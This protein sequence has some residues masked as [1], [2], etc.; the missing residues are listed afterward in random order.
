MVGKVVSHYSALWNSAYW[1]YLSLL[2]FPLQ[3]GIRK[4]ETES[5]TRSSRKSQSERLTD[6]RSRVLFCEGCQIEF[7]HMITTYAC[8]DDTDKPFSLLHPFPHILRSGTNKAGARCVRQS[9][10]PFFF[11][12][13]PPDLLSAK[14]KPSRN[15][16]STLPSNDGH[17][18]SRITTLP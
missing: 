5:G 17:A 9:Q 11:P 4:A 14:K 12:S 1:R 18:L 3:G 10:V 15:F 7:M 8:A 6:F 13:S 2:D 16:N